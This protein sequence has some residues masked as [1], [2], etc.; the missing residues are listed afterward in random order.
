MESSIGSVDKIEK[1]KDENYQF[2]SFQVK[3]FLQSKDLWDAV[4]EEEPPLPGD[5]PVQP[6]GA[7]EE[8]LARHETNVRAYEQAVA[9]HNEWNRKDKKAMN[10]IALSVDRSNAN[11]IYHLTS[12]K[13]AWITLRRH[14]M[15]T[16]LG[17]KLRT[18]K[19]LFSMK[20]SAGG[21]M[22]EHLNTMTELFNKLADIDAAIPEDQKVTTILTSVETEYD[23]LTT[24]IMAWSEDRLNVQE[25]KD[26]LIEEWEKKKESKTAENVAMAG[27]EKKKD[28]KCYNCGVSGHI[29]RNCP[30]L[31]ENDMRVKL[32][33]MR[34]NKSA[35][36]GRQYTNCL[37]TFSSFSDGWILDSGA[38]SH[39]T[40]K[41]ELFTIIDLSHRSTVTVAN[42]QVMEVKGIGKI[43]VAL[44][45]RDQGPTLLQMNDVLWVPDLNAS[46]FSVRQFATEGCAM[47]F[48]E[49]SVYF[50]FNGARRIIGQARGNHY[51][52]REKTSRKG[53]M[54]VRNGGSDGVGGEVGVSPIHQVSSERDG[55]SDVNGEEVG[56]GPTHQVAPSKELCIHQW[57]RRFAHRNLNDIRLMKRNGLS[58]KA[59]DCTDDCED[60]L[61]GKMAR[62]SF[63]KKSKPVE[64]V[65]DC[66]VSD[67]CGPMPVESVNRKR[68]FM[69]FIDVYS[70]YCEVK[71]L[72]EKNEAA[73]ETK[74]YI[75]RM[76]TQFGKKP[77]T[78]RSDRGTEYLTEELQQYL[79]NEGIKSECTVGYAP[80]QNGIAERKNRTLVEAARAMLRDS[81]LP[82]TFWAEAVNTANHVTNCITHSRTM[83]SPYEIFHNEKP[84]YDDLI[85]FGCE[86]FVMIPKEKRRKLDDKSE[87]M[88]FVGYDSQS[89]GFRMTDGRKV[90]VSREVHFLNNQ[91]N[92]T[93]ESETVNPEEGWFD[94][95]D[96]DE[97][98]QDVIQPPDHDNEENVSEDDVEDEDVSE[99]DFQS[100]N[101]DDELNVEE[102]Q[103]VEQPEAPV[104]RRSTRQNFGVP[105]QYLNDYAT[106]VEND[107]HEPKTY[108]EAMNSKDAIEWKE[109]MKEELDSIME[110]DT[111]ELTELP[112]GRKAV[113][114]KWVFKTKFDG[115]KNIIR[116]K[117]RLVAQ[118]F[119]Q[120]FG[121]DYDEVFAPVVRGTTMRMM[122]S[123]AGEKGYDVRQ[124][125]IKSAFLNGKLSEEIYMKPPQGQEN[126][127]MV[128][129]L[130]KSIYGLKQAA[131]VWN[132]TLHESLTKNGCKQNETD[133]CLYSLASG[134]KVI[135]L[136]IHVDD[137]LAA[138]DDVKMLNELM[139]NVGRDFELKDM[140]EAKSYLGID[141]KKDESGN[142]KISQP[143]YIAKIIEAAKLTDAKDSKFPLDVGYHKLQGKELLSNEVYRKLIGMLL[144]LSTNSRPDIAA[145]VAIL[146]QKVKNPRDTDMNEVKRVIRYLKGTRDAELSL[147]SSD[148]DRKL[149]AYSDSDWAEDRVN[150]KSH[151]GFYCSL[152]G[153]TIAWSCRKQDIVSL[154]S[155]EAE[156]VALCETAKELMWIKRVAESLGVNVELPIEVR[157]DSQSAIAITENQKFS[158]RT[159]HIDTKYHFVREAVEKKLIELVYHPT[160]TNIADMMTKPLGG[161]KIRELR[162]LAQLKTEDY[163]ASRA[164]L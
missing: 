112:K 78:L 96:W 132:Q 42:G 46:L 45:S 15:M 150:R 148:G 97:K 116:R 101:E 74:Q 47:V 137:I 119:S 56:N 82:K 69:T 5:A 162:E 39:M 6:Q 20:L 93:K 139:T 25:V 68:Y 161:N 80:E 125:D 55:G 129:R 14:H 53:A 44:W 133:N 90:I 117:A 73:N 24:A 76:K 43:G 102:E 64:N 151:S 61:V 71:F 145:S 37:S 109:A 4:E 146:S 11:L 152:S 70:R 18:K 154:S 111:W 32:D 155:A 17:N 31:R 8:V 75:E 48:D 84:R 72:R 29:K 2:W 98:D 21:S 163:G 12:G 50:E 121:V 66:V 9:V 65:L 62:K 134:G 115:S 26:R 86:A 28:F 59:C 92:A 88:K 30:M 13:Q 138:T 81:K 87:K 85:P 33:K 105:P 51:V 22:H 106:N 164:Q 100:A 27:F 144:Y 40:P 108:K 142:F 147:S 79:R 38:T 52:L 149:L 67:L 128:Y 135:H 23:A 126:A 1:L 153:G 41:R 16:T 63:P 113:G 131:R 158:H 140:G 35:D 123:V 114:S 104:L 130:R 77:K 89:K 58:I 57:H 99:N 136:L 54:I 7:D 141:I 160:A 3:M 159:K 118:G 19:K 156:Y 34:G 83:K 103:V 36:E 124:Y 122:L 49:E 94:F 120:K 91:K 143:A 10:F 95:Y 157:S 107:N 110:N 60:C 127:G